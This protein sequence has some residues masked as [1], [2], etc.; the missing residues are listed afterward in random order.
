MAYESSAGQHEPPPKSGRQDIA[1][2]VMADIQAR[3]AAGLQKYGTKLQTHNGRDALMDAY[4]EAIDLVMY[5][6]QAMAER[7]GDGLIA[8]PTANPEVISE[9]YVEA[10]IVRFRKDAK[11]NLGNRVST[12]ALHAIYHPMFRILN[13][14]EYITDDLTGERKWHKYDPPKPDFDSM[15]F[16][17]GQPME[18]NQWRERMIVENGEPIKSLRNVGKKTFIEIMTALCAIASEA[19]RH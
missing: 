8:A 10:W 19:A 4:Q 7:D 2:L 11:T 15:Y 3:V 16:Y 5:L 14:G 17:H 6:R 1:D 18:F 13:R 9:E 12:R